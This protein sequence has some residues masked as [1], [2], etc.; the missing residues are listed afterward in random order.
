MQIFM[1]RIGNN[2]L[3][4]MSLDFVWKAEKIHTDTVKTG[5]FYTGPKERLNPESCCCEVTVL[6]IMSSSQEN[7]LVTPLCS[8]AVAIC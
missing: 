8:P 2:Q 7:C 1:Q 4:C 6:P 5:K 3:K